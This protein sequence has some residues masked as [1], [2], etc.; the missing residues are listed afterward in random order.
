MS[1]LLAS[2]CGGQ[3]SSQFSGS[4]NQRKVCASC[5]PFKP[6]FEL[7]LSCSVLKEL[8]V[9]SRE[10][11]SSTC[12]DAFVG[13]W[14]ALLFLDGNSDRRAINAIFSESELFSGPEPPCFGSALLCARTFFV[15]FEFVLLTISEK[16][17][18]ERESNSGS[19]VY[20]STIITSFGQT[21]S[22]FFKI[23]LTF[24]DFRASWASH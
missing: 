23:A 20:E 22:F 18:P 1:F 14:S 16:E 11:S 9:I 4:W 3:R 24:T 2:F 15:F 5:V 6:Q 17:L 13:S 10:P 12:A 8:V 19:R 21:Q 7:K